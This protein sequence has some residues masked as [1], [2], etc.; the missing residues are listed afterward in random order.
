MKNRIQVYHYYVLTILCPISLYTFLN[1]FQIEEKKLLTNYV[2]KIIFNL[3][4]QIM[5]KEPVRELTLFLYNGTR[6][7]WESHTGRG[8]DLKNLFFFFFFFF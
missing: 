8:Y 3:N 1:K 7:H 2:S 5:E 6:K 4:Y